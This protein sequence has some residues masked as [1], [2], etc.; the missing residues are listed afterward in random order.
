MLRVYASISRRNGDSM[1]NV[2][3]TAIL[4]YGETK[5]RKTL[6]NVHKHL[7]HELRASIFRT[8][9]S[10]SIVCPSQSPRDVTLTS[11]EKRVM[12]DIISNQA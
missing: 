11:H 7:K 4:L 3:C 5:N 6:Y 12:E 8:A 2:V 10:P 9:F 1:A